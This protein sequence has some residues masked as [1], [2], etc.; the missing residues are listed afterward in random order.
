MCL[1]LC[2]VCV[3]ESKSE[4][5]V[6]YLQTFFPLLA[7]IYSDKMPL[8]N[9][10]FN[11]HNHFQMYYSAKCVKRKL[12]SGWQALYD[13]MH[14]LFLSLSLFVD[15]HCICALWTEQYSSVSIFKQRT[16]E[17][18]VSAIFYIL[19]IFWVISQPGKHWSMLRIWMLAKINRLHV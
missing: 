3:W 19:M 5:D 18:S 1:C 4:T 8:P 17:K 13:Q 12:T 15:M 16:I 10:W 2:T 6:L 11:P 9:P 7:V 14:L